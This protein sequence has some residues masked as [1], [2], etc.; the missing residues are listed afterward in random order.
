MQTQLPE[1]KPI[2]MV[3][4]L[5]AAVPLMSSRTVSLV[6][7]VTAITWLKTALKIVSVA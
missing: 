6:A 2:G 5:P 7:D 1:G 3:G 4:R